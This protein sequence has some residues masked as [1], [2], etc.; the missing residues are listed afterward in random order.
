MPLEFAYFYFVS[1]SFG[2]E[3]ITRFVNSSSSLENHTRFQ[4]KMGKVYTC[5]FRPR[6]PKNPT[7]WAARTD[8]A[9]I[10]EYPPRSKAAYCDYTLSS[11]NSNLVWYSQER[12]K[13]LP[14][15]PCQSKWLKAHQD[16]SDTRE[17]G[18]CHFLQ[19]WQPSDFWQQ[20]QWVL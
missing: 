10:R 17:R 20:Q 18:I 1:Y 6:R 15:Q 2:I 14:V 8:M 5:D 13:L 4:T 9:Y 12:S 3:R 11:L 7:L 19:Q 16:G